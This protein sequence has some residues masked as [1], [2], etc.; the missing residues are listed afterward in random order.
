MIEGKP[1][2]VVDRLQPNGVQL[3][4]KRGEH[5]CRKGLPPVRED[6]QNAAQQGR[7][8]DLARA[9]QRGHCR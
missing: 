7:K 1:A 6:N 8:E 5:A 4:P 9:K 3:N 2:G